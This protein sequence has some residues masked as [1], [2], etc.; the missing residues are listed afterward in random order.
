MAMMVVSV[1]L[2]WIYVEYVMVLHHVYRKDANSHSLTV[3]PLNPAHFCWKSSFLILF[4]YFYFFIYSLFICLYNVL[5]FRF[6]VGLYYD[7]SSG[8]ATVKLVPNSGQSETESVTVRL[9]TLRY[10]Y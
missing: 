4:I 5:K 6:G 7:L 9:I 10:L 8:E 1:A 2:N 3:K